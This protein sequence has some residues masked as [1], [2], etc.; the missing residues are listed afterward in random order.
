MV[1]ICI[2]LHRKRTG[3]IDLIMKMVVTSKEGVRFRDAG[4]Q[5]F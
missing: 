4:Q 2:Q 3:K 1:N 5:V